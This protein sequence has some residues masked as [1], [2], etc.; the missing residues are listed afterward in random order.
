MKI[1]L[2]LY[3]LCDEKHSEL[4]INTW[5]NFLETE[6]KMFRFCFI[7]NFTGA[8]NPFSNLEKSSVL[9]EA[10]T[11]N[12]TPINPRKCG[13]I[14]TKILYLINQVKLVVFSIYFLCVY[15]FTELVML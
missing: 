2:N 7:L 6:P 15:F 5:T 10:R 4:Y 8:G 14:L 13:H 1:L 11:F 9:Q 3:C 12:E